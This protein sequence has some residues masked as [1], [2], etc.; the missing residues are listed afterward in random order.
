MRFQS[1]QWLWLLVLL[2]IIWMQ[3]RHRRGILF[4]LADEMAKLKLNRG[5]HRWLLPVL[6]TLSF[7][8]LVLAM[9]RP[10]QG[11]EEI[12]SKIKGIDIVLALDVS[13]SMRA[14]DFAPKNR[15]EAARDVV[16]EFIK[17]QKDNRLGLVVFAGRSFTQC[18]LTFDYEILTSF[19][20]EI[21]VG[22]VAI[23]GTAI[24]DAIAN[25]IYKLVEDDKDKDGKKKEDA[26]TEEVKVSEKS[27]RVIILLT[28][29][30]NNS[31]TIDPINAAKMAAIK[32]IRIHTIGM[33]QEGGAPVP[34][35]DAF[36]RKVY[37]RNPDGSVYLTQINEHDLK[38]IARIT[39]GSYHRATN[40]QTL[41][42]IY[43]TLA[44]MEKAE[45]ETSKIT[46]YRELFLWFLIPA[47][48]LILIEVVLRL[49][50]FRVLSR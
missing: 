2:P 11:Q 34:A 29:G 40:N 25:A 20:D 33:G 42:D 24:G 8:L 14:E 50:V 46:Q 28:D 41:S 30:E 44:K 18:P 45:L 36:G 39:G 15:I 7:I 6:R 49:L 47:L 43:E 21:D 27:S 37:Q 38:E 12:K 4:P 1:M 5:I 10:Q 19:L 22:S 48:F 23:D 35:Y 3:V 13:G 32:G 17:Q 16:K 31:G 9:A 26:N